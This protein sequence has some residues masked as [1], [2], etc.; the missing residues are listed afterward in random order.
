MQYYVATMDIA[1]DDSVSTVTG[2]CISRLDRAD[3]VRGNDIDSFIAEL[4]R[5][6]T[7]TTPKAIYM[8][9]L[10]FVGLSIYDYL[11]RHD[12]GWVT[13]AH[14]FADN[15][16]LSLFQHEGNKIYNI[17]ICFRKR[18]N[19]NA[20]AKIY[21][22]SAMIP[23]NIDEMITK[24][25][26]PCGTEPIEA[27]RVSIDCLN[28]YGLLKPK[29]RAR[30]PSSTIAMASLEHFRQYIGVKNF[31][32]MFPPLKGEAEEFI[33]S[34]YF[35]GFV[36]LNADY[37]YKLT[38]KIAQK[39]YVIDNNGMYNYIMHDLPLP[40]GMPKKFDGY[41]Y[42]KENEELRKQYPLCIQKLSTGSMCKLRWNK[43]PS[44]PVSSNLKT[45]EYL[46]ANS[47]ILIDDDKARKGFVEGATLKLTNADLDLFR[48][49]YQTATLGLDEDDAELGIKYSGGYAFKD[50]RKANRKYNLPDWVDYWGHERVKAE[51][52]GNMG[53]RYVCKLV[54]NSLSGKFGS[55]AT[56]Y[57]FYRPIIDPNINA[58]VF[59]QEER[60]ERDQ[61]GNYTDVDT[62]TGIIRTIKSKKSQSVYVPLS[63]FIT[64][65]GRRCTIDMAQTIQ[66][67]TY[68]VYGQSKYIYSDTDSLH[69]ELDEIPIYIPMDKT[70]IGKWKIE[71]EF[72][73]GKYFAPKLYALEDANAKL[74]VALSGVAKETWSQVTFENFEKGHS[75]TSY[76]TSTLPGGA[77]KMKR[78]MQL[79]TSVYD[80]YAE[81]YKR[82]RKTL[83]KSK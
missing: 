58:V 30:Y 49:H 8:Y 12:F 67:K 7:T 35:G 10:D 38:G 66:D 24:F 76:T 41:F 73:R 21:N 27:V 33:R 4:D 46:C 70:A 82:R 57:D 23:L 83:D 15:T 31:D 39:G 45:T 48:R 65:Y 59:E 56:E 16:F 40:Y 72:E 81:G 2:W 60:A 63:V 51:E 25:N 69:F 75:Y 19:K 43:I 64:S 68:A 5:M 71:F 78:N 50:L 11:L 22:A 80:V 9:D 47:T 53:L 18:S 54:V 13:D 34:C 28:H 3:V 6:T 62:E 79:P 29:K 37:D 1:Y 77:A 52:E 44:V 14:D 20:I 17:N 32:N 61:Y 74:K 36:Y 26:L 42:S 55:G